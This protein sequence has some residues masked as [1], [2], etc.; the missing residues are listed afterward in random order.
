[1]QKLAPLI[2]LAMFVIA[3]VVIIQGLNTADELAHPKKVHQPTP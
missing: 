1:M 3:A 2:I